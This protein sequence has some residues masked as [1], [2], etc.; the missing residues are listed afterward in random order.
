[1]SPRNI[2]KKAKNK[3]QTSALAERELNHLE[4]VIARFMPAKCKAVAGFGSE[5]W[6]ERLTTISNHFLLL[7]VQ[8]RRLQALLQAIRP[9][10]Q[11]D[12]DLEKADDAKSPAVANA[13]Q[14]NASVVT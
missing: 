11:S 2:P 9:L 1:M 8:Q 10:V 13:L 12:S 4:L 3:L 5:Y 14:E 7:P 6:E